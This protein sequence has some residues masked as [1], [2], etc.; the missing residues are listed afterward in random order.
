VYTICD[1]AD[2]SIESAKLGT[3]VFMKQYYH[4]PIGMNC[5]KTMQVSY[6][7]AAIEIN[8]LYINVC[9][10]CM[11]IYIYIYIYIYCI[12]STYTLYSSICPLV[13]Q[14]FAIQD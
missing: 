5:A 6:I 12:H 8:I 4:S 2:R 7:F 13:V 1:N 3:K 11:Y 14:S 9:I 10:L